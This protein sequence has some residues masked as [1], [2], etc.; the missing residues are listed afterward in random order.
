MANPNI[1]NVS[2]VYGK[3]ATMDVDSDLT[4]I[5]TASSNE[6]LKINTLMVANRDSEDRSGYI[7][8]YINKGTGTD[9]YLAD[10][11]VVPD[12]AS[13]VLI[14]KDNSIYLEE[15]DAL[16]LKANTAGFIHAVCSYEI[17]SDA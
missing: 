5:I 15:T 7:T 6:V 14:S 16:Q 9:V 10:E 1:V 12:A 13:L 8:A 11:V 4:S 3:L 17:I 2:S